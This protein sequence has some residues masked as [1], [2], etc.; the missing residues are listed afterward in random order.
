MNFVV[1]KENNTIKVEREFD[2]PLDMVWA[3]WTESD[4]LDQW[5]APKPWQTRTKT[6]DFREGGHWLYA[7]VGPEGEEHW[8]KADYKSIKPLNSFSA[9]DAFCDEN[10]NVD[11]SHPRSLWKNRFTKTDDTTT[12]NITIS[13]DKL[14]DLEK[15]IEMGFKEGFT[16]GL[17]N[18][19]HYLSTQFRLRKENKINNKPR[20][21]SYLNFP[22][23]TE[24]AFLFYKEVFNGEFTGVGLRRFGDIEMPADMPPMSNEDKKLIIH[25]EL[26]IMGGHVLMATDSPESMGFKMI[27][28][29][30][31][32]INVEPE[33]REE[34]ERLFKAL[35]EGGKIEMPLADMF[36]GA[37]F[38]AF[39][40][41]YGIN[42]M[43][44]YQKAES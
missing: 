35:S 23:K 31:M 10:G 34:T 44:H 4:L 13:Y 12:V 36:W 7:M 40:D 14:S 2:A 9:L 28:G 17:E 37:Y 26:T 18:L 39:R 22:G 21:T 16:A 19:D 5:W 43:L 24:E 32:H 25:A 11:N 41:K 3:A 6:M 15:I 29:N 1:D 38:A 20:V 42:W 8:C 33:S 30:N 27:H